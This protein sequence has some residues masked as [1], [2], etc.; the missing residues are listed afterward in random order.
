MFLSVIIPTYWNTK[1]EIERCL[2]SI[3]QSDWHDFE[4]LLADDGNTAEYAAYLDTLPAKFSGLRILHLPHG[5]ESS[6]RNGG[7]KAAKGE[8]IFLRMPMMLYRSNFVWIYRKSPRMSLP[9]ILFTEE[10]K[11]QKWHMV[12]MICVKA[13]SFT[14]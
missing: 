4:V 7:I 3:Y 9:S 10:Y 6:A 1:E 13:W 14:N 2:G 12:K 5:G 11:M 8:F